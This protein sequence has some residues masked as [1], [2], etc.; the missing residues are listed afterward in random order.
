MTKALKFMVCQIE[1]AVTTLRGGGGGGRRDLYIAC[2]PSDSD[3]GFVLGLVHGLK[4]E[5]LCSATAD[6]G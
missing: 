6:E 4:L 3:L 5:N 1:P 2:I